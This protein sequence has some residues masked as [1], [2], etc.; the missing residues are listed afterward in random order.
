M[1]SVGWARSGKHFCSMRAQ[2]AEQRIFI[3]TPHLL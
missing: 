3:A 2:Q 1:F